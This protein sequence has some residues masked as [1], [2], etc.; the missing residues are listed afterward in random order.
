MVDQIQWPIIWTAWVA[1]K[2]LIS[3]SFRGSSDVWTL[4]DLPA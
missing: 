1:L 2:A 4:F 3:I